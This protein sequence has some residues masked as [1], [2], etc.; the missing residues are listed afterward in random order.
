MKVLT[1][2][3]YLSAV[4]DV[5]YITKAAQ[6]QCLPWSFVL[7]VFGYGKLCEAFWA[8]YRISLYAKQCRASVPA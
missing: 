4:S 7:A 3:E 5:V 6:A 1:T 8:L 2:A